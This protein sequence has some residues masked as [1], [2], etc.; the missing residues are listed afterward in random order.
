MRLSI[1]ARKSDLA[2]LQAYQVGEALQEKNPSL[3]IEYSFRESLG[4]KNLEDPLWRMPE[5][6]VF[7]EDFVQDLLHGRTD[8][9][10][11][12][13]KDLP[14]APRQGS[15]IVATLPRAD[16]RD[17][18][19][20]KK[21]HFSKVKSQKKLKIF[22]SSPRRAYNLS[23]FLKNC[24]PAEL[25]NVEFANV[26]GNIQTRVR[27]LLESAEVDGLIVAKA[28]IDRLLAATASEFQETGSFLRSALQDLNWMVLPL[29]VNPNAAAQ[30]ALAVEVRQDRSDLLAL[31]QTVNESGSFAAA[32]QEREV[33]AS[34]GGG[35][36]QKIGVAVLPRSYGQV[37]FLKGLTDAGQVLDE[38]KI[39][40]SRALARWP[41]E[42]M[43]S[44]R[45]LPVQREFL[46]GVHLPAGVNA[47][48]VSKA[49]AFPQDLQFEG[50][51]WSAGLQTWR[52]LAQ[53]GL[54]VHGCSEGLGED[55][56]P[57]L[58]RLSPGLKW[59]KLSHEG[60]P[61]EAGRALIATYRLHVDASQWQ[62]GAREVFYWHSGSQFLAAY[63]RNPSLREKKHACG[64]GNTYKVLQEHLGP[65]ASVDVFLSEEQ[66][67]N[68]CSL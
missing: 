34:F 40:R 29:S 26:R 44:S 19:L 12:S 66:W 30:G 50:L 14:T 28:A 27:K 13:W 11:H 15:E 46:S 47:L 60:A 37:F 22:S 6:G 23:A 52:Q 68:E 8:M 41:A 43:A 9:V 10:V 35:C 64:P 25:E 62:P 45:E 1:S 36:H 48:W 7:T 39:L 63:Q 24:F 55:E 65:R 42:K 38:I 3:Q 67:R 20:F 33:L 49:E 58:E 53:R 56:N 59:A 4:D 18:L 5:K 21:K 17:L 57:R 16:Q 32:Q 51:L 2:R 61:A 54:W 31:L